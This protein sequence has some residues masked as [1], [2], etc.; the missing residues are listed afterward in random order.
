MK[1]QVKYTINAKYVTNHI[2]SKLNT[3]YSAGFI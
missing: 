1:D 2:N 3:R